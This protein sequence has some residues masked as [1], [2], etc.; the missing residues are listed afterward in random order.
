MYGQPANHRAVEGIGYALQI[1]TIRFI[2]S[3]Q[4]LS[5]LRIVAI[6]SIAAPHHDR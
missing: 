4:P 6:G 2:V 5:G 3:Q 1:H